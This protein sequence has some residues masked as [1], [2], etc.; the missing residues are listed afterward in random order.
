MN[1]MYLIVSAALMYDSL[2]GPG[3]NSI[4]GRKAVESLQYVNILATLPTNEVEYL[5]F[6]RKK[7][8]LFF[9]S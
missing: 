2:V 9:G 3:S 1:Q 7:E 5:H 4:N 8:I 6:G